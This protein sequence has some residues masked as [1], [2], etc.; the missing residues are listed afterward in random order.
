MSSDAGSKKRPARTAGQR[1]GVSREAVVRA[2]RAI[3]DREGVDQVTMRRLAAELGVAPNALYTYF[4]NK[5]AIL[6]AVLDSVLGEVEARPSVPSGTWSDDLGALMRASRRALLA[7]PQ[8]VPLFIS[9]PGGP[10]AIRLGEAALTCLA[11]GGLSGRDA[12]EAMRALLVYTLGSAAVEIPRANDPDTHERL[13]RAARLI[14]QLPAQEFPVTRSVAP[15]I[16]SHPGDADF[17][18]GLRWL[19]AGI[20]RDARR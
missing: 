15:Y 16:A 7:H 11:R 17:E 2:A 1:A 19:I 9:R 5:T 8:L 13:D 10:N 14:E 3:A 12:V 20:E 4:P 18:A 6:D